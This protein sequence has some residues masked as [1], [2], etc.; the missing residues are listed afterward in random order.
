MCGER[1]RAPGDDDE[2]GGSSPRVR[3]TR[4]DEQYAKQ[5]TRIIP[6][7]AGN[8][9]S[10]VSDRSLSPD[11][12]R[13][14]GERCVFGGQ[15][16]PL[17]GSSPR[18]RGTRLQNWSFYPGL[19]IIPACAGN[20]L[21]AW[22]IYSQAPDHP[23]VCGERHKTTHRKG[24]RCGSS[25]R[26]RGTRRNVFQNPSLGRIIPACAGNAHFVLHTYLAITDHPRVC[27]ERYERLDPLTGEIGSS[28]RV[29]G[30]R[31]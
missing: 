9:S 21:L 14:C 11:H 2:P 13:V 12:P 28:P 23:R 22:T 3:G 8:A 10:A 27:G 18:V 15:S 6:A 1:Q 29:R 31:S 26:V 25:P 16:W 30:T 17:A 7:C 20:A 5:A 19:R 4:E 24:C